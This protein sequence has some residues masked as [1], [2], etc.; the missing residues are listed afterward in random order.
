MKKLLII[1]MALLFVSALLFS[2]KN[3]TPDQTPQAVTKSAFALSGTEVI[4]PRKGVSTLLLSAGKEII[5]AVGEQAG[6]TVSQRDDS[7]AV[8]ANEILI[9]NTTRE[10]SA[11][12]A[13]LLP[14][15]QFAFVIRRTGNKLAI[16]GTSNEMTAQGVL[17]FVN[18][19]LPES[20]Q[21]DG[22]LLLEDSYCYVHSISGTSF[23]YAG[24]SYRIVIAKETEDTTKT[25]ANDIKDE[26]V[27]LSGRSAVI[28]TDSDGKN[29]KRDSGTKE[30]LVG[31]TYYPETL[32]LMTEGKLSQYGVA[33]EGNKLVVFGY[34]AASI[35]KATGILEDLLQSCKVGNELLIPSELRLIF[36]D[37]ALGMPS[38]PGYPALSMTSR[39]VE[40]NAT[41]VAVPNAT[42]EDFLSYAAGLPGQGYSK[43]SE[44]AVGDSLFG[45]FRNRMS[46]LT[47]SYDPVA[48]EVKITVDAAANIPLSEVEYEAVCEP[49]LTQM[50][51]SYMLADAGMGYVIRL[52]DG[53]FIVIDGGADDNQDYIKLYNII[54]SQC[55]TGEVP[56]IAAWILTHGHDDHYGNFFKFAQ[57]YATTG[58]VIVQNAIYNLP[59]GGAG[60]LS[61]GA[62]DAAT[63]SIPG[64][65][66]IYART[67]QV[68]LVG[69]AQIEILYTHED[70]YPA[71]INSGNNTST[72]FRIT[73]EGQT[74]MFLGDCES[75]EASQV[76]GRYGSA[77]KSDIMQQAHHG[78]WA[79][80]VALYQAIDP[81]VVLWPSPAHWYYDLYNGRWGNSSNKWITMESENVRQ[82]ILGA[83]E[84][85]TLTLPHTPVDEMPHL[86]SRTYEDGEILYHEDFEDITNVYETGYWCVGTNDYNSN[87]YNNGMYYSGTNLTLKEENGNKGVYLSGTSFS[88][89]GMILP[90]QIRGAE[91]YTVE[92]D[93]TVSS[94]DKG[95]WIWFNDLR[96]V[97][98]A[99][100]TLAQ[101]LTNGSQRISLEVN[102]KEGTHRIYL[103]GN[104]FF[105]G[106]NDSNDAGFICLHSQ[107]AHAFIKEVTV[108][109]GSYDAR[110]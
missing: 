107:G 36:T 6:I 76:V 84:T 30:I 66:L 61:D 18:N 93:L 74:V 55:V 87:K 21:A 83:V 14:S 58:E 68:H 86:I 28:K 52:A 15:D 24:S 100:R 98:L 33:V 85:R 70:L 96:P 97:N 13:A 106:V 38:I 7:A 60:G 23:L 29:A 101:I 56:V 50:A 110:Q 92:M 90:E 8:G 1:A 77:L 79:G 88:V 25:Y 20:L 59:S 64:I 89:L 80:S 95:L 22:T 32:T 31:G 10:E 2:C 82:I 40:G 65:R 11:A 41:E 104:L 17:Y 91:I 71:V 42:K 37:Q 44:S 39:K 3:K 16:V 26:L 47:L 72:I 69:G 73:I 35:K 108:W 62:I 94:V 102:L 5:A 105:E 12:A 45:V 103:N 49:L 63:L 46:V 19:V 75:Q 54:K 51:L 99:T 43:I 9:G 48:A 34:S 57:T 53:R 4:R 81:T 27:K 67:G 78:Y 109:A